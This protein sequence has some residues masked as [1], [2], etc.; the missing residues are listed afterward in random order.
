MATEDIRI[1]QPVKI[2]TEES[3]ARVAY[4]LMTHIA[5]EET[6]I[7]NK[8]QKCLRDR[9]YW[10]KLYLQCRRAARGEESLQDILEL[11]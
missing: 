6:Q 4:D 1:T 9:D 10:L 3:E 5:Y 8:E 2:K 11:K 7:V